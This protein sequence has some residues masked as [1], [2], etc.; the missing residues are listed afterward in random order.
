VDSHAKGR[1]QGQGESIVCCNVKMIVLLLLSLSYEYIT[2][3]HVN[4]KDVPTLLQNARTCQRQK[5]GEDR[6][7]DSN[8]LLVYVSETLVLMNKN[9]YLYII[10]Y[11]CLWKHHVNL[12]LHY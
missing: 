7:L 10:I 11:F 1:R 8:I 3:P 9:C 4:R 2:I 6:Y 12:L 5:N